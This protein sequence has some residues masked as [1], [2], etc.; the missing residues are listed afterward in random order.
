MVRRRAPRHRRGRG[1]ADSPPTPARPGSAPRWRSR[2]RVGSRSASAIRSAN[3]RSAA[4]R[5]RPSSPC[6]GDDRDGDALVRVV[7]ARVEIAL[8]P[9][10]QR[11][12]LGHDGALVGPRARPAS[13]RAGP[14]PPRPGSDGSLRRRAGP[15]ARGA[16][17]R[18]AVS[19]SRTGQPRKSVCASMVSRVVPGTSVTSARSTPSSALKQRRLAGVRPPGEH[20]QRALAHA[21]GGWRGGEEEPDLR[22]HRFELPGDPRRRH[23]AVVLAG[24][25][26]LVAQQRLRADQRVPELRE[27][28]TQPAFQL[29][30]GRF[31]PALGP[32]HRSGRPPPPPEPDRVFR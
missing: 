31:G 18:P 32:W 23:R 28:T 9:D 12:P 22:P 8:G 2:V 1:G 17:Q 10:Q 21:L 3:T 15:P 14:D 24:E 25:V 16:S 4:A 5:R 11:R 7:G 20:Q 30:A 29:A 19:A 6:A 13:R 27:S 26:D